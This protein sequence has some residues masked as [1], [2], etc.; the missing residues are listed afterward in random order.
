MAHTTDTIL[1]P[2]NA[3]E[4][5]LSHS[6]ASTLMV[7]AEDDIAP[8]SAF[9]DETSMD[10][11]TPSNLIP[12]LNILG[13]TYN[14]LNGK[15]A[16]SKSTIQQVI[17]W[18]K[19]DFRIQEFGPTK[20]YNIPTVVNFSRHTTSDLR[21]SYGK[22]TADYAKSLSVHAGLEGSFP[23]FSASASADYSQSQRENL[24]HAFTRVTYTVTHYN[25]ALPTTS[26]IQKLLKPLFVTDLESMD[27]LEFYKEYGTHLLRSLTIGGHALFL[28]STDTRSYSS[29]IS[30]EAAAKISAKYA[31]ASGS[32]ELSVKEKIAMESFN[33]SSE[34]T[35]V[36]KGGD[37][38]YGNEDFL[39]HESEWAGSILDYPQFVDFGPHPCLTGLWEFA[40]TPERQQELRDAFDEVGRLY[41]QELALP[42]PF[43]KARL[44][45][46]FDSSKDVNVA[47]NDR[48]EY[49]YYTFPNDRSDG[50]YLIT[51]GCGGNPAVIVKELVPGAL[52]EVT[53]KEIFVATGPY[54]G[55]ARFWKAIPPSDDY[56][57]MGVVADT[58][59]PSDSASSGPPAALAAHFRAV[60]KNALTAAVTGVTESYAYEGHEFFCIDGRYWFADT[61]VPSYEYYWALNPDE[62]IH[63][64]DGW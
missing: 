34:T 3:N 53:W 55:S 60:H 50:W 7:D 29:D 11:D 14:V 28:T 33:E 61:H 9:A 6:P 15:Y 10:N 16:D 19:L 26:S 44:T 52:A 27:P 32:A 18:D 54:S 8:V 30:V 64:G 38:Q 59:Y 13:S 37:P 41:A 62:V 40:T 56:V 39:K 46:D 2:V 25:L 17:D 47:I 12:G 36:T 4:D 51:P 23:G 49:T 57:A 24:S 35:I 20:S 42:G 48:M 45:Y 43:L 22:T 21:T 31:I 5:F 58:V 1:V 63:E